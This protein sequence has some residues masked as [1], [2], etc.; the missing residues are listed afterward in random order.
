MAWTRS[1]PT[2][3]IS[4]HWG[5]PSPAG[6]VP[7][8]RLDDMVHR[9]LRAMYEVGIFDYP[10]KIQAIPAAADAAVAQEIEEQ[11]AVLL[12]NAG[13]QLPLNA[14][15]LQSIAVIGSHADM[16]MCFPAAARRRLRPIGA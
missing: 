10:Q 12:K 3:S 1:S 5:R 15:T 4:P 9:I 2:S 6:Q 13:N 14:S 7:Q 8:S 16:H 11:G